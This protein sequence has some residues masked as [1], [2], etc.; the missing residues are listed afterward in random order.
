MKCVAGTEPTRAVTDIR[1]LLQIL[2]SVHEV[3]SGGL[4]QTLAP[5]L[6]RRCPLDADLDVSA[7]ALLGAWGAPQ[8]RRTG[9]KVPRDVMVVL[10]VGTTLTTF[11]V[12]RV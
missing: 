1:E 12:E 7:A 5:L 4:V 11:A 3:T 9:P 6:L 10:L 8:H 2:A